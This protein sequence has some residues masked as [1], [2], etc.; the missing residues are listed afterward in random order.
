MMKRG[1]PFFN[2]FFFSIFDKKKEFKRERERERD[3]RSRASSELHQGGW[4]R[5]EGETGEDRRWWEEEGETE[6]TDEVLPDD[7][8][9]EKE[10]RASRVDVDISDTQED[11]VR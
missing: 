8:D 2:D 6:E 11:F 5:E 1:S 7:D 4:R 3:V 10:E 9:D